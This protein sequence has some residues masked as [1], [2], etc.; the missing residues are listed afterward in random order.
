MRRTRSQAGEGQLGCVFGLLLLLGCIFVAYKLI[1]VKVASAELRDIVVDEAKSAGT[2]KDERIMK[3]ILDKAAELKLPVTKEDVS[4]R[5]TQSMINVDVR[6]QV[7]VEF[8]GYTYI[9]KFHHKTENPI[10]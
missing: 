4:I 6:Y 9:W 3:T 7:P 10:F 8:P 1:P 5:R 2:H